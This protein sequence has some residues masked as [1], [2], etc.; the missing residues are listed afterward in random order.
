MEILGLRGSLMGTIPKDLPGPGEPRMALGCFST[1]AFKL[2][3][4]GLP[5]ETPKSEFQRA[6]QVTSVG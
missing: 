5:A 4:G 6:A 3:L 1:S 2:L